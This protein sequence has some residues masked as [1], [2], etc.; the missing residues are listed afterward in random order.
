M[1]VCVESDFFVHGDSCLCV[2]RGERER[3]RKKGRKKERKKER[4]EE[5]QKEKQTG[6]NIF[7]NAGTRKCKVHRDHLNASSICHTT[8]IVVACVG[9]GSATTT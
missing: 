6:G 1:C 9:N 7:V 4:K 8:G 3:E 2:T 5:R